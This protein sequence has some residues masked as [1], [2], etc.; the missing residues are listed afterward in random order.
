[1]YRNN[2]MRA[3]SVSCYHF[4]A[5]DRIGITDDIVQ[6]LWPVLF[7]PVQGLGCFVLKM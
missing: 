4:Q 6:C 2:D 7:D 3:V 1:M 5:L